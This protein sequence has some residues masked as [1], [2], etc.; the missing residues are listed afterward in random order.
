VKLLLLGLFGLFVLAV[1]VAVLGFEHSM[2]ISAETKRRP[3]R[4]DSTPETPTMERKTAAH[5][6][7]PSMSSRKDKAS[8]GV[9]THALR[10]KK[11]AEAAEP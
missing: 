5:A 1:G 4:P 3:C 11:L 6:S 10:H 2:R 9:C 8:V 7:G